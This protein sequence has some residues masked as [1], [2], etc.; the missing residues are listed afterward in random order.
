LSVPVFAA[1]GLLKGALLSTEATSSLLVYVSKVATFRS[2]GALPLSIF[3]EGVLVGSTLTL[4]AF[5]GKAVVLRMN[6]STFEHLLDA[7]MLC[8]G[9]SL[10]WV[11]LQQ[12]L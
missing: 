2:L 10:I 1:Y 7:M 5:I 4:G 8:S 6:T 9:V 11:A 12:I 3:V